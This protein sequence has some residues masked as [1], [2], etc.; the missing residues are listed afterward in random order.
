MTGE[1]VVVAMS[2]G[3]DS[4]VTAAL[5]AERGYEVIGLTLRLISCDDPGTRGSCC[6]VDA[7]AGARA[8]AG[9]LGAPHYV[10]DVEQE[11]D[12]A[13]LRPAWDEYDRGRTP[14]PCVLCNARI[15]WTAL[16]RHADSFGAHL[17]ATGHHAR[18]VTGDGP[19]QLHRGV[20]PRK[21]QS[22]FL[23]RLTPEQ[24]ARTLLPVGEVTKDE[25]R[26][27]ARSLGLAT[28]EREESQDACLAAA[29]GGFAEALRRRFDGDA[30]PGA[31]LDDREREVGRHPGVHRFTIGQ[32]R[33][34][35]VALGRPAFVREID[36]T[37]VRLTTDEARLAAPGLVV[38]DTRW[39]VAQ[40]P[41]FADRVLVQSRYRQRP[42]AAHVEASEGGRTRVRFDR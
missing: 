20:D 25:V 40:A 15:K 38:A 23:F 11:F 1:R 16:L 36:G 28:A 22:Y 8:V 37:R 31:L 24:L 33:G 2:G 17:V 42:V 7:V 18:I 29:E 21:D 26:A 10:V 27:V 34:L 5:L 14:N 32:R 3:V 30:R 39:L 9:S 6:D 41:Q 19:A 13:V 35:G 12:R 4:S